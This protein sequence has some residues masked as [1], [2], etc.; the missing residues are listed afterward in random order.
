M[1]GVLGR[2]G[3]FEHRHPR[4]AAFCKG[5]DGKQITIDSSSSTTVTRGTS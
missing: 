4:I 5:T 1:D 3:T 2:L